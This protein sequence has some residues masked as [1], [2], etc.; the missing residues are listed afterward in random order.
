MARLSR[1]GLTQQQ[2]DGRKLVDEGR[3]AKSK[4][5]FNEN[6]N[7]KAKVVHNGKSRSV[8]HDTGRTQR[9]IRVAKLDGDRKKLDKT[10]AVK[11][12][13][14]KRN[15]KSKNQENDMP[16]VVVKGKSRLVNP[17]TGRA[18]GNFKVTKLHTDGKK[19]DKVGA[20]KDYTK[21]QN[22]KFKNQD[23]DMSLILEDK[24]RIRRRCMKPDPHDITNKRLD[25][26]SPKLEHGMSK[27]TLLLMNYK[28]AITNLIGNLCLQFY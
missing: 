18:Q 15:V 12:Y 24:K 26:E 13:T 21:L 7:K 20:L 19:L 9:I 3:S 6:Q 5:L 27:K 16:K 4:A 25:A 28:F 10:G 22:V 17:N 23:S 2:N 8:S 11:D 14:Q 1:F